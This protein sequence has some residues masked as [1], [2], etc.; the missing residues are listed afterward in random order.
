MSGELLVDPEVRGRLR[1]S[2]GFCRHHGHELEATAPRLTVAILYED[3]LGRAGSELKAWARPRRRGSF[4][5]PCPACAAVQQAETG[6]ARLMA[7]SLDDPELAA[8]YERSSGLC[9]PHTIAL[10]RQLAEPARQRVVAMERARLER[11]RAEL[12]EVI[13]KHD[14]RFRDEPWG[15][16]EKSAPGRAAAK[17]VGELPGGPTGRKPEPGG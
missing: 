1:A 6:G 8:A 10:C 16:E 12:A 13:R 17:V 2:L 5:G 9:L 14:Y 7:A 11:L 4:S 3:W 15:G